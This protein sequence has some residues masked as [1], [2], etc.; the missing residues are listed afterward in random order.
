MAELII[1]LDCDIKRAE[2]VV[3]CVGGRVN[4]FKVGPV[5]F[6]RYGRSIIDFLVSKNL[7]VFLDLKLHDIPNTVSTAIKNAA[8][9]GV[10]SISVHTL[11]GS[12]MLEKAVAVARGSIKLW[13][14]TVLTSMMDEDLIKIGIKKSVNEEVLNLAKLAKCCGVDGIVSSARDLDYIKKDISGLKFITPS[15]RLMDSGDDQKRFTSPGFA[16][17]HGSDYLVVGRP[18]IESNEPLMVVEKIL[19]EMNGKR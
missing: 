10:Y 14:I 8:D 4:F 19:E 6:I 9:M 13:G 12:E 17:E 11:G 18:V 15:I 2:E 3:E 5:M 16:V 7:K 1:A